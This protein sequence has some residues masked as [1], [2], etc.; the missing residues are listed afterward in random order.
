MNSFLDTKYH[1]IDFY[2]IL[3]LSYFETIA[4]RQCFRSRSGS[5]SGTFWVEAEAETEA[6]VKKKLKA[7]V[8]VI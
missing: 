2:Q 5:G 3:I 4:S 6:L 7:E 8:E 1:K